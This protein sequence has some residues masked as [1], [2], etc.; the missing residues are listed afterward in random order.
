MRP[1]GGKTTVKM[2]DG[3]GF[4][5]KNETAHPNPGVGHQALTVTQSDKLMTTFQVVCVT[6]D[7]SCMP[8]DT[9]MA[10]GTTCV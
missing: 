8:T 7:H 9:D 5:Y 3:K 6:T 4:Q 10:G 2:G 1:H